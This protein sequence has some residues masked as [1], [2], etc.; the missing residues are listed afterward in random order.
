MDVVVLGVVLVVVGAAVVVAEA[1]ASTGGILGLAGVLA[2][3]AG[4]GLTM[5]GA[6]IPLLVAVPVASVVALL[7]G[8]ATL[9][10]GREVLLA[11][12]QRVRTGPESLV[13]QVATVRTWRYR[14]GQVA[15]GGSLWR[16]RLAYGWA[17]PRPEPGQSVVI[18]ELHGL[19]VS[20]RRPAAGEEQSAWTPSS[21]SS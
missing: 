2:I 17:D 11:R 21:L 13:G 9:L 20:I 8:G 6:G 14:E 12:R 4:I 7:G 16:A 15:I 5:A 19:T 3:V 18:S 10:A 1:H